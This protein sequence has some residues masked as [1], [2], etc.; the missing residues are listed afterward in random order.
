M[1]IN[2]KQ[3]EIFWDN[4]HYVA[5]ADDGTGTR[6]NYAPYNCKTKNE[7][8]ITLRLKFDIA[9]TQKQSTWYQIN[10]Y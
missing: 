10:R 9:L 6:R 3:A 5:I 1:R 4:G 8:E 2:G 7:A